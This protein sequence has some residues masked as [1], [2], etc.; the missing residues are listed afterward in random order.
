MTSPERPQMPDR[1]DSPLEKIIPHVLQ[2]TGTTV[3]A[4]FSP[5]VARDSLAP[6]SGPPQL[7]P[8]TLI[9]HYEFIRQLGA[10]GMGT[11]YLARDT[12]LGRLVAIK[13]LLNY[14]GQ[15]AQ[16]FLTEARTTAQCRH[17]NIVVVYE[18]DEFEGYP[19][20]VLEYIAGRSL[21][22]VM[23]PLAPSS[24]GAQVSQGR[25]GTIGLATEFM[26]PVL[27]ALSCAHGMGIVHRDL[28]PENILLSDSG[29][30]KVLDFGI[31]KQISNVFTSTQS[32]IDPQTPPQDASPLTQDGVL[33][34]T[35][36]YM[37]PEQMLGQPLDARSDVWAAGI[38]L[39]ELLTGT[40][41]LHPF[42]IA[43]YREV[44]NTETPMPNIRD[45]CPG[46]GAL[47]DVIDRCLKKRKEERLASVQEL[48]EVLE[49]LA[50]DQATP[51]LAEDESPFAG[52]AA[53]QESDA[54][55]FFGRELDV[56]ALLGK[57]RNHEL[58]AVAG[59]SGAGKSSFVRAGIIPALKRT[60]AQTEA[61]IL[62]P[63]R[64]PLSALADVLAFL[65]DTSSQGSDPDA[66]A[67]ML[68]HQPGYFGARLRGRCRKRG[69]SHRILIFVDQLEE[70]YTLG[71]DASER[72][73]FCA[74]LEGAADD[75]SSPL[76]VLVTIRA[77][78]L[79]RLSE[80]RRFTSA[81]TRGLVLLP[82]MS[83]D[84]LRD[85]L[86]K[87]LEAARYQ[88][89]DENLLEEMLDGVEKTKSPLPI[90]QFTATKLW[91]AR[92]RERRLLTRR[93]YH[94]I[95]GVAGALSTH[96]DAVLSGL[97][98]FEQRLARSILLRL[99]TPERTR[100][101]VR[102]E[103]LSAL[104]V[105]GAAVQQ[106][107]HHLSD[108]RLLMIDGGVE[109][110]GKTV[111]LAHESLI[112]RWEK[113][114]QWLDENEHEAQF[115]A[116]L[117][118]AAQQWEKNGKA[119]GFLW[120]DRA[121]LE[122]GQWLERHRAEENTEKGLG[123]GKRE[124]QYLE[125]VVRL[126][127]RTRRWRRRIT[128]GVV[129]AI[130]TTAI[131]V[132]GLAIQA[133]EEAQR[134]DEQAHRADEQARRADEQAKQAQEEARLARNAT[135]MAAAHERQG[136]P[137][138]VLA[139]LREIE[140][141][142][143]P[144]GWAEFAWL[145]RGGHVAS[146]V[147]HH[148]NIVRAASFHRDGHHIISASEDKNV[149]IWNMDKPNEAPRLWHLEGRGVTV[150]FS[151][152]GGRFVAASDDGGLR[153]WNTEGTQEPIL[154]KGHR[155]NVLSAVFSPDGQ[156]I[157]S[158]SW[159][160]TVRVWNADG[161][162]EPLVLGGH[163]GRVSSVAYRPDGRKIVS[164]SDDKT[165]RVWNADGTG[166]PIVLKG[167]TEGVSSAVYSP[168]GL[169][170]VSGSD[171]KTLRVWDAK[172][173]GK[174]MVLKGHTEGV[175]SVAFSP[176][177]QRIVSTS[178]DKTIRIWNT[179]GT[180][181]P[182]VIKAHDAWI[183][184]ASFSPDGRHIVSASEDKTVRVWNASNTSQVLAL[185]G[186][187]A[188]VFD[189]AFSP[190]GRHIA[191]GSGDKTVRV[192]ST[193]GLEQP[194]V[195]KGHSDRVSR[196]VYSPDGQR[197]VSA[198]LDKTIRI[199]NADGT[200]NALVLKGHTG[201]VWSAAFSPD[202]RHVV[203]GSDDRTVRV[204]NADGTGQPVVFK[205]HGKSVWSADFSPDGRRIAS[206]SGDKTLRVWNADGT[207]QPLVLYGHDERVWSISFSPDG[208]R[209]A[210][211]SEDKTVR[212]WNADGT[213]DVL[214]LR[215]HA[216]HIWSAAFSPDGRRIVS[217]SDDGTVR[218]WDADGHG[219]PLVIRLSNAAV[220]RAAWSP[221]GRRIAAALDDKTVIVLSDLEPLRGVEDPRLW[222]ATN[223]CMP[224]DIRRGLLE[225]LEEQ[226]R[227]DRELCQR[228]VAAARTA[229]AG[230]N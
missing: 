117:R 65:A 118:N 221:D 38:I 21:R 58:V 137:T 132:S 44:L 47:A 165:L 1:Q 197:I 87:P 67:T 126:S 18:V 122:A 158:A 219:E 59:P 5:P 105:D 136:D 42:S 174:A 20:I 133:R 172:G 88:F 195:F 57:L 15:A 191:S 86:K 148:H 96:A 216:G 90:L 188:N 205:G 224:L 107:V 45:L 31:A 230:G 169:H 54:A 109:R 79:D 27:R 108:A 157:A 61:F 4:P 124:E 63:G 182:F 93:A 164:A 193:D 185:Q 6:S 110:E 141:G 181:Q 142:P 199:W 183:S 70:L 14:S 210:S 151:P 206:A 187:E 161:S 171:D 12:R 97:S 85:S 120:R 147:F 82:P 115:L 163:E 123:L 69:P 73:T 2:F 144:R 50:S 177:G 3:D 30:V 140:P 48:A 9:K 37:S 194:R 19:Y 13:F 189:A 10:G 135:R 71:I 214:V 7:K 208:K 167:H 220:N 179:D 160:K 23:S 49:R 207:G 131:V 68:R 156:R 26:V 91:E 154:L 119:E 98:L 32:P 74:C 166:N 186:H 72:A 204:W 28:K 153:V 143:A 192:W 77:D 184:A 223:Y 128:I 36:P 229:A 168:D 225:F 102:M 106:V 84:G 129:A 114:R 89:E 43:K 176:D 139:L 94:A 146:V 95:G 80:D 39:F 25:V 202:G 76:R 162:G 111:E 55:R 121:A 101:I 56:T 175:S 200:G 92:D 41:P 150:A 215:G 213:G 99:V 66:L 155:D 81:V 173:M 75:A 34:G 112:E 116:Q 113:L 125:A 104:D 211:A 170:I 138:M 218:V 8:G 51:A 40:H 190:D 100:A 178:G 64:D 134:A 17:E 209:I 11:V 145:A 127:E 198:S 152:D 16:R 130:S 53:F 226:S 35:L 62:R 203:S 159:D 29:Q 217:A 222:T 103:E 212:I 83:R 22:D 52:L 201:H 149:Y 24:R 46:V 180:G 78:F 228:R 227:S 60:G 33:V 196:V